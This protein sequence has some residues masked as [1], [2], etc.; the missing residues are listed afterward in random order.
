MPIHAWRHHC[1]AG[2]DS[3]ADRRGDGNRHWISLNP[4][5]CGRIAG[6]WHLYK[7]RDIRS[8]SLRDNINRSEPGQTS[9]RIPNV[10][11]SRVVTDQPGRGRR[12][13]FSRCG[14]SYRERPGSWCSRQADRRNLMQPEGSNSEFKVLHGSCGK[15]FRNSVGRGS[16]I[17]RFVNRDNFANTKHL[18]LVMGCTGNGVPFQQRLGLECRSLWTSNIDHWRDIEIVRFGVCRDSSRI[19]C[20]SHE[21]SILT[22]EIIA[23]QCSQLQQLATLSEHISARDAFQLD[24]V[25]GKHC[26]EVGAVSRCVPLNASNANLFPGLQAVIGDC[27]VDRFTV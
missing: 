24:H 1:A 12:W 6:Q 3:R 17:V 16:Q 15:R 27:D 9:N 8:R 7:E 11:S 25:L 5:Q 19:V 18:D 23:A 20:G 4:C 10:L 26:R 22:N 13:C 21:D 14:Q 2:D